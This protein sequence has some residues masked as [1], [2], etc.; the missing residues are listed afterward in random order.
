[1]Y[2]SL[3]SLVLSHV[4]LHQGEVRGFRER[5]MKE[6]EQLRKKE[7]QLEKEL[8]HLRQQQITMQYLDYKIYCVFLIQVNNL[9]FS[10]TKSCIHPWFQCAEGTPNDHMQKKP[11]SEALSHMITGWYR[12]MVR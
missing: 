11:I 12:R 9:W 8:V 4:R 2:V 1:M 10:H 6:K 3:T 5:L 7:E